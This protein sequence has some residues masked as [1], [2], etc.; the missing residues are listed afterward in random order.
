M[1]YEG[2]NPG[3]ETR[4]HGDYVG[5]AHGETDGTAVDS[6][7]GPDRG[8]PVAYDATN[9]ELVAAS[10]TDDIVGVLY[11]FPVYG[12]SSNAGPY[13]DGSEEATVKTSGEVLADLSG[14]NVDG[15]NAGVEA[16]DEGSSFG[17]NGE[18]IVHKV[19]DASNDLAVVR[20]R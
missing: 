11:A 13:I 5:F 17:A 7:S 6:I 20:L 14:V 12:D 3:D 18:V 2:L 8:E 4:R 1:V 15:T 9:D 19:V 16:D 10:D